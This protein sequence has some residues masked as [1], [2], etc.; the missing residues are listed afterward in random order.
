MA[1]TAGMVKELRE[2]TG[3][4]MMT[5]KKAL[6]EA[7][8]DMELAIETLRKKGEATA[9]KRAGK[10]ASEGAVAAVVNGD[11][12]VIFQVNCETDFSANSGDFTGMVANLSELFAAEKPANAE[13]ALALSLNGKTVE[14]TTK[15]LTGKIGEKIEIKD[16][17]VVDAA[18]GEAIYSYVHSNKKVGA[19]VKLASD[20]AD[21]LKADAVVE[22]G[23]DLAMQVA[24]AAPKAIN[25]DELDAEWVEKEKEIAIEQLKNE[26]KPEQ[27]IEK[28]V[29]GKMAKLY[30]ENTLV[31]QEFIKADKVSVEKHMEAIAKAAGGSLAIAAIERVELGSAE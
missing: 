31:G 16:L 17:T 18:A 28:I 12:A 25:K 20:N 5:C 22:L 3:L 1:I 7:N 19:L 30:K 14:E 10:S 24:A 15:E 11:S 2:K 4:G 8:G 9:E 27:I 6:N 21:A 23:K 26:G 13:A 29:M